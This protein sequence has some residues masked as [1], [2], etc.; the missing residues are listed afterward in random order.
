MQN[1]M[2]RKFFTTT[3]LVCCFM[4]CLA[5]IADLSGK[6]TGSVKGP[7]GND[8][9]L[10][11]V[12]KVDGDKLTGTAQAHGDP[13]PITDCKI[14]GTDFTFSVPGDDDSPIPHTGKYYADGDSISMTINYQGTKFHTTLKRADK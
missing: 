8:I 10:T 12:F 13:K 7:D 9:D 5:V 4:V 2:K 1:I 14:N 3:A 6:W 11:Y